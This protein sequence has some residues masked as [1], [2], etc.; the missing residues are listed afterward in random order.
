MY[1][2]LN[3]AAAAYTPVR[4]IV[5][6][7]RYTFFTS[8]PNC[9]VGMREWCTTIQ[10]YD[11]VSTTMYANGRSVPLTLCN[12]LNICHFLSPDEN[13]SVLTGFIH[14]YP[15]TDRYRWNV[16][17]TIYIWPLNILHLRGSRPSRAVL[18]KSP[19]DSGPCRVLCKAGL[20]D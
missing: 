4:L 20:L 11:L 13:N 2:S 1:T 15:D 9:N 5:W 3:L 18:E 12:I 6:K 19:C 14:I 10:K 8:C 16:N 17:T 7:L